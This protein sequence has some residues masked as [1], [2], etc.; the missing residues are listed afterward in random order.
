[1]IQLPAAQGHLYSGPLRTHIA[2]AK[3]TRGGKESKQIAGSL[4]EQ[5]AVTLGSC[6][7]WHSICMETDRMRE[8]AGW[9]LRLEMLWGSSSEV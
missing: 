7:H 6:I 4:L 1:M 3:S 8:P 2:P 5:P 9:N